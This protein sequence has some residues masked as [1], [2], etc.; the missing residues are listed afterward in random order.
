[1]SAET[2]WLRRFH[3]G[4]PGAPALVCLPPAGGSATVYFA[5]SAHLH[6]AVEVW[7]VQY[8]GHLGRHT[9][10]LVL[11]MDD[12]VEGL[13]AAVRP[14]TERPV[15]LFG[16]SMGG[17][18]AYELALLLERDGSPGPGRLFAS[19]CRAPSREQSD[20]FHRRSDEELLAHVSGLGVLPR[21]L[22]DDPDV[23]AMVLPA[24]RADYTVV[25]TH[26][27]AE[28]GS[29]ACPVTALLG[30]E[31]PLVDVDDATAWTEH[32]RGGFE[33]EFFTGGHF[34]LNAH[35]PAL[36]ELIADRLSPLRSA[37]RSTHV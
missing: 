10:P 36:A 1:M 29:L 4:D 17:S 14:L 35:I 2:A 31:D 7:A 12:M 18:V 25:E 33:L 13:A 20:D 26:T 11:A 16:H 6:P 15:A 24:L 9:E 32:T 19:G 30:D 37:N 28:G 21:E 3:T 27:A 8:P 5:L 34:Y 22:V 23:R